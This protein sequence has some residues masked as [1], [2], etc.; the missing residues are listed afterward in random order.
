MAFVCVKAGL[1]S[2]LHC[3]LAYSKYCLYML[4]ET[5]LSKGKSI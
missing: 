2:K 4:C 5:G 3:K 1:L